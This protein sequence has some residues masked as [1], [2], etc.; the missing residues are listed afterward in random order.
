MKTQYL[1]AVRERSDD[2]VG[3][4]VWNVVEMRW[5]YMVSWW[6]GTGNDPGIS[7]IGRVIDRQ[8]SRESGI[9]GLPHSV[10]FEF[11]SIKCYMQVK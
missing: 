10:A 2:R 3:K 8:H 7:E 5:D 1:L 9:H 11:T 4:S 6:D